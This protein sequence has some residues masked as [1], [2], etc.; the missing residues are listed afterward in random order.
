MLSDDEKRSRY[1]QFGHAGVDPNFGAGGF[2]GGFDGFDGFDLGDLL[3]SVF[4]GGGFGG[5]G[6]TRSQ[7]NA[8]RR[9]SDVHQSVVLSFE[10]AAKGCRKEIQYRRIE[11]CSECSGTGAKKGTSPKTCPACSGTGMVKTQQRTPFGVIQS[12]HACDTCKGTGKVIEHKCS[13]CGGVG[14]VRV[15]RRREVEFP[16]GVN[17]GIALTVRGEGGAGSN[18]GPAGDLYIEITVRPH[19]FFERQDYDVHCEVPLTFAQAALG[20]ELE[21][22]TIDGVQKIKVPA[23]TQPGDKHTM[24]NKGIQKLNSRGKGDQIVHFTVSVPKSL[25]EKQKK[26]IREMDA[27]L[28]KNSAK[29]GF[30]G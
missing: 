7:Q 14:K 29:T 2:G 9:G 16:A 1:D 3:G 27:E 19:H 12:Q 23:G 8:P 20:C 25:N 11:D 13:K 21:I 26:L 17:D 18:G 10:E 6:G 24:K 4:G 28:P 5:F 22:M 30:F 15:S